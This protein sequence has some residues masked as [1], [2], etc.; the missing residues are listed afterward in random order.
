MSVSV[1]QHKKFIG[2]EWVDVVERRDDGGAEPGDGR[3]D[4]RGAAGNG[5]GRRA[6]GRGREERLVRVAAQDAEGP[7][8][9]PA[10]ARRRDRRQRRGADAA[11]VAE[12]RQADGHRDG[13]DAVLGGQP[14]LL[15][16]RRAQPRGEGR[17]GV[18]R[19]LHVDH[20]AR[21]ARDRGGDHALELPADD[22]DLEARARA[23][24]R[25][26]PDPEAGGADTADDA[27]LR[28]AR[29]GVPPARASC[30]S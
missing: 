10:Q 18:R 7:H 1:T 11:R 9:A 17:R 2:G 5:R 16:R 28:G 26:R 13:R 24:R 29:A 4:R 23:R 20:P 6:R 19:G 30:R 15:R 12:R 25:E 8:G 22:G 27:P 3:G 21:A 14:P